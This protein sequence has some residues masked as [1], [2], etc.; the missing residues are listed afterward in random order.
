[1]RRLMPFSLVVAVVLGSAQARADVYG[2]TFEAGVLSTFTYAAMP[3]EM[4]TVFVGNPFTL[5]SDQVA[6]AITDAM[7]GNHDGPRTRF[8]TTPGAAARSD[9]RIVFAFDL[10]RNV[11]PQALCGDLSSLRLDNQASR[12][13]LTAVF[14]AGDRL[15][16]MAEAKTDRSVSPRGAT[17]ARTVRLMTRLLIRDRTDSGSDG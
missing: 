14:C 12:L 2:R 1:M 16:S 17:F 3:G 7:Y 13:Y 4:N 9:Y 6:A 8:T 5:P 15:Q 11:H 10:P